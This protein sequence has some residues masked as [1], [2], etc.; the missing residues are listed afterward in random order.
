MSEIVKK[1]CFFRISENLKDFLSDE[2]QSTD[3]VRQISGQVL[4]TT[5]FVHVDSSDLIGGVAIA[6]YSDKYKYWTRVQVPIA[7]V[8]PITEEE[9]TNELSKFRVVFSW[10][11]YKQEMVADIYESKEVPLAYKKY[12]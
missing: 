5:Y 10:S 6:S 7:A 8:A 2:W 4:D 3:I 1:H 12:N 11:E 9:F